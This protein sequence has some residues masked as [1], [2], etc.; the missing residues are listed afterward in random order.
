MR[1]LPDDLRA[2]IKFYFKTLRIRFE[3]FKNKNRIVGILPASLKEELN[4]QINQEL[5]HH[6]NFF[7][8]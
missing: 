6:V 8:F 5:I 4:L 1:H 3:E 7:Q 2:K